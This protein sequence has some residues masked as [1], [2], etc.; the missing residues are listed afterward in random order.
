MHLK[1][2]E[3]EALTPVPRKK[4]QKGDGNDRYAT[5]KDIW[6]SRQGLDSRQTG[7]IES[8]KTLNAVEK[9]MAQNGSLED[10]TDQKDRPRANSV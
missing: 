8:H 5:W 9:R 10:C 3:I 1:D 4:V 6:D 7:L 2:R